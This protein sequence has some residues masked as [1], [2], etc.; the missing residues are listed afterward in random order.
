M[1]LGRSK[2][3]RLYEEELD[4]DE[5]DELSEGIINHLMKD[6]RR[7]RRKK[8][9]ISSREREDRKNHHDHCCDT[10]HVSYRNGGRKQ[11]TFRDE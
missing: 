6:V 3:D 10:H 1:S 9:N 4:E 8:N 5:F 11:R 7:D 2:I